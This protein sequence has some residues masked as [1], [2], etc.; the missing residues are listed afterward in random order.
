MGYLSTHEEIR[1]V[2][3]DRDQ[4]K[5]LLSRYPEVSGGEARQIQTLL[6]SGR[7]VDLGLPGGGDPRLRAK[8][9]AYVED[10]KA[11]FRKNWAEG[12]VVAGGLGTFLVIFWWIWEALA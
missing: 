5:H 7:H 3:A 8:L 2:R 4:L 12:A 6:R 11:R 1:A 10:H 9:K